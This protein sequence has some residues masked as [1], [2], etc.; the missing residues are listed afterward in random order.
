MKR[1]AVSRLRRIYLAS[2]W[3]NMQQPA[4][5]AWLRDI[6]HEVYDFRNPGP[7]DNGFSWKSIDPNWERWT[8]PEYLRALDT[9]VAAGGFASDMA[10]LKMGRYMC[11]A[12]AVRTLGAS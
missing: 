10:G 8:G 7:G 6:G 5:V 2:S 4:L 11:S 9:P 12:F 3:R 1:A